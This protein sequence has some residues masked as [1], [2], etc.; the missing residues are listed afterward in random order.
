MPT[1]GIISGNK[2]QLACSTYGG[3]PLPILSWNCIGTLKNLTTGIMA[4]YSVEF[5]VDK[6]DNN[7]VCSCIATHIISLYN[8]IIQHTLIVHYA[9]D[10]GPSIQQIPAGNIITGDN[11]M[12][13]CTVSG[14]N[15]LPVLSWNCTGIKTNKTKGSEASY[16]VAF[17][18]NKANNNM[19]CTC[20]VFY[21]PVLSYR[22]SVHHLLVVFY[23]PDNIPIIQQ[24][25]TGGIISGNT[26]QLVCSIYGG[27]PLPVLSW[28]CT[29]TLKNLTTGN[30]ASY[31][32]EIFVDKSD[33]N[34]VCSC[35][36][37]HII[38][39]Y[40]PTI[41]HTLVVY[42]KPFLDTA[43]YISPSYITIL[44][45]YHLFITISVKSNPYPMIK[46]TFVAQENI[47]VCNNSAINST[48]TTDGLSSSSNIS[49]EHLK[50]HMFGEYTFT[51]SNVVGIFR[52]KFSVVEK[53]QS[54]F[55]SFVFVVCKSTTAVVVWKPNLNEGYPEEFYVQYTYKGKN[56]MSTNRIPRNETRH[57]MVYTVNG[58]HPD[59]KYYFTVLSV[60]LL[61][62][63]SYETVE[64]FT[65][66]DCKNHDFEEVTITNSG[67]FG[68][69]IATLFVGLE[70]LIPATG[71]IIRN[72]LKTKNVR[73]SKSDEYTN[74]QRT[75][76]AFT[77]EYST[78]PSNTDSRPLQE[79]TTKDY[80]ECAITPDVTVYHNIDNMKSD[81]DKTHT[82]QGMYANIKA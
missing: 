79:N 55:Q 81:N 30:T 70:V 1:G 34:K 33:N 32:V 15:P 26:M 62:E 80:E 18:V 12:L 35:I 11:L 61:G 9:P 22:P 14:G 23:V 71:I 75:N 48:S 67:M 21:H 57:H 68:A 69:G 7:K 76:P 42:Y 82:N 19:I 51:A 78:L 60:S 45:N 77:D 56:N 53:G 27:N 2:V 25:P 49:I 50:R 65:D 20:S 24:M 6:S 29:G 39:S 59:R 46:W 43:R 38:S 58:L 40:N 28:N 74:I 64:C 44:E 73:S 5:I 36:A 63:F 10:T 31:S 66:T 52:R 16:S 37:T 54:I 8:P 4:S 72:C 41:Q 17:S 3:N 47:D 13:T